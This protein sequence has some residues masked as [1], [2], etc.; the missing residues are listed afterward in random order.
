[1]KEKESTPQEVLTFVN[2]QFDVMM[3]N[4][5]QIANF[6]KQLA[7]K[8]KGQNPMAREIAHYSESAFAFIN[9]SEEIKT[10]LNTK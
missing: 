3:E 1:M 8:A 10:V 6:T 2:C 5:K 7:D 9:Y 4:V